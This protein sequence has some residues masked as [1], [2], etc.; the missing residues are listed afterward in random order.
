[1]TPLANNRIFGRRFSVRSENLREP[2]WGLV[3]VLKSDIIRAFLADVFS[4]G[5]GCKEVDA[6]GLMARNIFS[7]RVFSGGR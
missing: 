3:K 4:L 6:G 1:M 7:V 5:N 2:I